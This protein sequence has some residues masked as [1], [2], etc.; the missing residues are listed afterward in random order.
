MT[1]KIDRLADSLQG[2]L[3]FAAGV[4]RTLAAADNPSAVAKT[5][6][7][8]MGGGTNLAGLIIGIVIAAVIGIAVGIPVIND[9]INDSNASGTTKTILDLLDL[10]I[11][12][13]ILVAIASPLMRRV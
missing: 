3:P 13:L 12:L 5:E 8:Q 2:T 10:F 11:G 1:S 9:V 6:R 4:I 7:A